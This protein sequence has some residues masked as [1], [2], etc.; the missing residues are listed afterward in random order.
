MA[1]APLQQAVPA[2]QRSPQQAQKASLPARL[3]SPCVRHGSLD[4]GVSAPSLLARWE[5]RRTELLRGN[6]ERGYLVS[7]IRSFDWASLGWAEAKEFMELAPDTA[8]RSEMRALIGAPPTAPSASAASLP[9]PS[10]TLSTSA[11]ESSAGESSSPT[12][13]ARQASA[14]SSSGPGANSSAAGRGRGSFGA[15]SGAAT[16]R[17]NAGKT[18]RRGRAAS[19]A[20]AEAGW[21]PAG[22]SPTTSPRLASS[23]SSAAASGG[24]RNSFGGA[25]RPPTAS[26]ATSSASRAEGRTSTIGSSRSSAGLGS[27]VT[28][29]PSPQTGPRGG[30][31]KAPRRGG[32]SAGGRSS[33]SSLGGSASQS[34]TSLR[35]CTSQGGVTS[36]A[37]PAAPAAP[38][39]AAVPKVLPPREQQPPLAQQPLQH[40]R[41]VKAAAAAASKAVATALA[42]AAAAAS[43]AP[44]APP[45]ALPS[46]APDERRG[47]STESALE[48]FVDGC[49]P[50]C[51]TTTMPLGA[52]RED[53]CE[54]QEPPP[55]AR[56]PLRELQPQAASLT[57]TVDGAEGKWRFAAPKLQAFEFAKQLLEQPTKQLVAPPTSAATGLRSRSGGN[58]AAGTG[59]ATEAPPRRTMSRSPECK[60][61]MTIP[62][63]PPP[64]GLGGRA[65]RIEEYYLDEALDNAAAAAG[66]Q[67]W[68]GSSPLMP[69]TRIV[70]Q[71]GSSRRTSSLASSPDKEACASDGEGDAISAGA[72]GARSTS[73]T[74]TARLL[75][76]SH[77]TPFFGRASEATPTVTPRL[78]GA[79]A[80]SRRTLLAGLCQAVQS[81]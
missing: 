51:A 76:G 35:R 40:E 7:L 14:R 12:E 39:A 9:S 23:A 19:D 56:R 66:I 75:P 20:A 65:A 78:G 16:S 31:Q 46:V 27:N 48:V 17:G 30:E 10:A 24:R 13:G 81:N 33:R 32:G 59:A 29:S 38:A 28:R 64:Q 15:S 54:L 34:T 42:A 11:I 63:T 25:P 61:L 68:T 1:E 58:A 5:G 4:R 2:Q 18:Q 36:A 79:A 80:T 60:R 41:A 57:A 50:S 71:S 70:P 47:R 77:G 53:D 55:L 45:A 37:A 52:R 69:S 74:R 6:S 67:A 49:V 43:P 3:P 26:A 21:R 72:P 44:L 62:K 73:P 8:T 22:I